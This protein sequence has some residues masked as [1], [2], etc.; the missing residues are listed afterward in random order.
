M[1]SHIQIDGSTFTS[2]T[3]FNQII[4]PNIEEGKKVLEALHPSYRVKRLIKKPIDSFD[5][6]LYLLLTVGAGRC[7]AYLHRI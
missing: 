3:I 4:K 1:S 2:S 6:D 7:L 5:N